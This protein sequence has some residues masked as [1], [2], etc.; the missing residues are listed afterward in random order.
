V[1]AP[2]RCAIDIAPLGDLSDPRAVVRLAIAAERAG[3]DGISIWDSLGVSMGGSAA[4]PFVTLAA[5]AAAT[6]RLRLITSV[7]ALPR[8]RPQLVAQAIAT[9][10][11]SSGGRCIVGVGGGG[12]PGDFEPFGEPFDRTSRI[13]RLDEGV[14]LLDRFLRG[15]TVDHDGPVHRVR[16]VAV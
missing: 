1:S 14:A 11:R 15:E 6:S 12:D 7:I 5:V 3:W 16:G 13:A 2:I 10:D 9:L 4:D 8:R